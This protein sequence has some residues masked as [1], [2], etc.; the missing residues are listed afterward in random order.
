MCRDALLQHRRIMLY[1]AVQEL[2]ELQDRERGRMSAKL[3][4]ALDEGRTIS[5][6]AYAAA[7][8]R[9][10]E[11][12]AGLVDSLAGFDAVLTPSA[13][14]AAPEDL[15]QTGDP[16]CC[17][18][19]SLVGFPALTLPIALAPNSLPLGMQLA[20]PA[21]HENRLL[22][23]AIWCERHLPFRGLV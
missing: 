14:G 8:G 12:I 15:T 20:A 23:V 4:M 13:P 1:E 2:G 7:L 5:G 10:A 3:N 9:R 17:S 22:A 21:L 18:L 11:I 19:W 16:S 6:G